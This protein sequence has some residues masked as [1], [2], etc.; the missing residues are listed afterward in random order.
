[1]RSYTDVGTSKAI[2][3]SITVLSRNRDRKQLEVGHMIYVTTGNDIIVVDRRTVR[4]EHPSARRQENHQTATASTTC[5]VS[6]SVDSTDAWFSSSFADLNSSSNTS[7]K[8][9][10]ACTAYLISLME[11]PM[12]IAFEAS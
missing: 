11:V 7:D 12:A 5:F 1:M 8:V 4:C 6:V 2:L 3:T 10:W 9:G